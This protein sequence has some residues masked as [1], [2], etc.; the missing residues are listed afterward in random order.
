MTL[1]NLCSKAR[2]LLSQDRSNHQYTVGIRSIH[3]YRRFARTTGGKEMK[4]L[5]FLTLLIFP[6]YLMAAEEND[7]G[8][9][10]HNM[11]DNRISLGLSTKVQHRLLVNMRAQLQA[12]RAIIDWIADEKYEKASRIS[13]ARLGL[14]DE[15]RRIYD[16]SKNEDFRNLGL[17]FHKSATELEAALKTKDMK[18][19]LRALRDTMGYCVQCH[20]K[21]RQ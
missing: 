16:L 14:T 20:N 17:A 11:F 3:A 4:K 7:I 19:S 18:K 15:M 8:L 1:H 12:T 13:H 2:S 21:F 9:A 5:I 6:V 10:A